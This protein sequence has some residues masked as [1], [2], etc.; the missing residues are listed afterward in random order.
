VSP[1]CVAYVISSDARGRARARRAEMT[2]YITS[3]RRRRGRRR[4][5]AVDRSV[6][7]VRRQ[8]GDRFVPSVS[9]SVPSVRPSSACDCFKLEFHWSSFLVA[10]SRH[11]RRHARHARHHRND[12]VRGSR[13]CRATSP[14]SLP[15]HLNGRPAVCCGVVLP[16]CPCVVSLCEFHE[17]D[18]LRTCR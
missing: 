7:G 9:Q 12:A 5:S 6:D 18:L 8:V 3:R 15:R 1:R 16:V 17:P 2:S 14:F 13:A 4:C 11:P 10:F